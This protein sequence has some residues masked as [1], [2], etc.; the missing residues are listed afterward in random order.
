MWCSGKGK[1]AG[2]KATDSII[3][4]DAIVNICTVSSSTSRNPSTSSVTSTHPREPSPVFRSSSE[5]SWDVEV[6]D[7]T[8]ELTCILCLDLFRDPTILPCGHN[9]CKLCIENIW[10]KKGHFVC[11]EC[12]VKFTEKKYVENTALRKM[13]EKLKG[14][15]VGAVQQTCIEHNEPMTL[16]WKPF[17]KLACF[18]CREAQKPKDQS[19][20]FLLI[21]DAVQIYT[22]KL[23]S[24]RIQLRSI[25]RELEVLTNAQEEK[26]SSHKENKL[27]LQYHIALEFLKLHQFLHGKEKTLIKQLKEEDESLLHEMETNLN[28]LQDQS[29]HA[30]DTLV[31]IQSRLYQ[32]HSAMFLKDI[33]AFVE[34]LER[35]T[36]MATPS[37]LV[38]RTLS[39][40][41]FKGPMQY[42]VW[43]EMKSILD[44][45]ISFLTLDPATAHPNLILSGDLTCVRHDDSKQ[46]LP[47]APERFDCSVSVLGSKSFTSGKHYWEVRVE[48][49]TK[50][51]L[52]VVK[53]SINRKGNYPLSPKAGH[54]LIKL[55][56]KAGLRA[57]DLPPRCLTLSC[58]PH[59]VGVYLD[60]EGGQVSFY[61]ADKLTHI[62][63]FVDVFTEKLYPYF[64]PCLNDSGE[65]LEP[66]RI[67]TFNI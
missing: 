7:F 66:L 47:D 18:L 15:H 29:Q 13:V 65:N 4:D 21:P 27:Q 19:A 63:T 26:I 6:E 2:G 58:I 54:W 51:T 44:P 34:W 23:I 35:K 50:W 56:N 49:K 62:Y 28:R 31:N 3:E 38:S 20:Q 48:N 42:M 45:D 43:K 11:P 24:F 55:R 64:C 5:S 36:E 57:V 61:D 41:Q 12:Q 37:E 52:G 30:K 10:L 17:K 22:E 46:L 32:Q 39:A 9:Y 53:E 8:K 59:R 25:L 33:Q 1:G 14:C 16:Y 60:Y 40:G 67:V